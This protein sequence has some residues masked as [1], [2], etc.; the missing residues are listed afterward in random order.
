MA[1]IVKY[2]KALIDSAY[3]LIKEKS[4]K[5]DVKAAEDLYVL[6]TI[7]CGTQT[8]FNLYG[9]DEKL[10][11]EYKTIGMLENIQS[12]FSYNDGKPM[13]RIITEEE[14]LMNRLESDRIG[15]MAD[16]LLKHGKIKCID[17]IYKHV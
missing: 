5:D 10:R 13:K 11:K 14:R 7:L 3:K 9:V 8:H 17:E 12:D 2:E 16:V 4:H 1:Y 6:D 15:I